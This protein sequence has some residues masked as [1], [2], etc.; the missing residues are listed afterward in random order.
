M[1]LIHLTDLHLVAPGSLLHGLDPLARLDQCLADI[2]RHHGDADLLVITGDLTDDGSAEAYATLA[3]RLEAVGLPHRLLL[4]NHDTRAGFG[5][6]FPQAPVDEA[7]F[8]QSVL[9][10]AEAR[11]IFLDSLHDGRVT[12]LLCDERLV[13]LDA[14]LAEAAG[15]PAVLFMHHP[16]FGIGQPSLDRYVLE[17]ESAAALA[18]LVLRHGQVRQ[19]VA[20]H[21]HR[22]CHG[23]WKGIPVTTVPATAHQMPFNLQAETV[24][25]VNEPPAYAVLLLEADSIV[26]HLRQPPVTTEGS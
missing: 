22:P 23:L 11:L 7:G 9:D 19:I 10:T 8:V 4:G 16:P 26:L 15:R 21:V 20:G 1:K 2:L 6:T 13:W 24:R 25:P 3:R 14:R 17:P 12:G 18:A 5:A